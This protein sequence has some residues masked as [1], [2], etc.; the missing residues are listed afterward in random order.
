[1]CSCRCVCSC[2]W[3]ILARC[4]NVIVYCCDCTLL[5]LGVLGIM[6]TYC[7]AFS[8]LCFIV[9]RLSAWG[10]ACVP[11]F[12]QAPAPHGS[13]ALQS[14]QPHK[15]EGTS[16][17]GSRT[18]VRQGRLAA[19]SWLPPPHP[20][21]TQPSYR[22]ASPAHITEGKHASIVRSELRCMCMRAR[23]CTFVAC[24]RACVFVRV[25]VC[26]R[27]CLRACACVCVCVCVC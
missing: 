8:A 3:V 22:L 16:L 25:N 6:C 24:A 4:V 2:R 14:C 19:R 20:P 23:V 18:P 7:C 12:P 17:L 21:P 1:M 13:P 10:T 26:L 27:A 9:K 5:S 11:P 15:K